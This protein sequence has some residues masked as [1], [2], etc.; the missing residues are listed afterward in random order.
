M[1]IEFRM[2]I[3]IPLGVMMIVIPAICGVIVKVSARLLQCR[4]ISWIKGFIFGII[5]MFFSL[6]FRIALVQIGFY[7]PHFIGFSFGFIFTFSMGGWFFRKRGKNADGDLL[8]WAGAI[9]LTALSYL[10]LMGIVGLLAL[11]LKVGLV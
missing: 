4:E 2:D 6:L 8:G 1:D 3:L 5:I 10:I 7:L 9:K 11:G